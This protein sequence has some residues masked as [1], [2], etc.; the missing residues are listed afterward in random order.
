[1]LIVET[2]GKEC[3]AGYNVDGAG[4]DTGSALNVIPW[5]LYLGPFI[6]RF[7]MAEDDWLGSGVEIALREDGIGM[8]ERV[9]WLM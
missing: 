3:V 1:M 9:I 4:S 2:D 7:V 8:E 6:D 5:S